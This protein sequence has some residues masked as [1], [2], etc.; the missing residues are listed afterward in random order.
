M[1]KYNIFMKNM[2]SFGIFYENIKNAVKKYN[3]EMNKSCEVKF[4]TLAKSGENLNFFGVEI[5]VEELKDMS[6]TNFSINCRSDHN[7]ENLIRFHS[8]Y[9]CESFPI[10][11]LDE[12]IL[13]RILKIL[14]KLDDR[15]F[16]FIIR[17]YVYN[18]EI[19]K[20]KK[21]KLE[22]EHKELMNEYLNL[23]KEIEGIHS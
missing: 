6:I 3:E 2:E 21:E 4:T 11:N 23:L 15:K 13:I 19:E 18:G 5:K 7:G 12:D 17:G 1:E 20:C 16:D 14:D 9:S 22:K 8:I 10:K